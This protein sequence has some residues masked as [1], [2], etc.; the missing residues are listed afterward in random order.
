MG[1]DTGNTSPLL[2]WNFSTLSVASSSPKIETIFF[3]VF[4]ITSLQNSPFCF[5]ACSTFSFCTLIKYYINKKIK[6]MTAMKSPNGINGV[7]NKHDLF[8]ETINANGSC[9]VSRQ[10]RG[11]CCLWVCVLSSENEQCLLDTHF[12]EISHQS[13]TLS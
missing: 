13:L 9:K 8:E 1:T 4:F 3:A 2:I 11:S 12:S 10:H 7:G 5:C 6:Q